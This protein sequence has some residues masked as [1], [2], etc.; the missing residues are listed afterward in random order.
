M[1]SIYACVGCDVLRRIIGGNSRVECRECD[2]ISCLNVSFEFYF[3]W[4]DRNVVIVFGKR[5][6][7]N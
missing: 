2:F 6:F 7:P 5:Q 1:D 3:K 4:F